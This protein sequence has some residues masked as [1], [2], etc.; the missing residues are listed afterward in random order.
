MMLSYGELLSVCGLGERLHF[1]SMAHPCTENDILGI[2]ALRGR[3][4]FIP[5][6]DV[7]ADPQLG[8][9]IASI[10]DKGTA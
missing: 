4:T 8:V 5:A 2:R 1:W 10:V 6:V 3:W 7:E 9:I